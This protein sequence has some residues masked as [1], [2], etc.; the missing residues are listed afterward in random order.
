MLR[1]KTA[2]T[3]HVGKYYL[4]ES[5]AITTVAG[6]EIKSFM[7]SSGNRNKEIQYSYKIFKKKL[8]LRQ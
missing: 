1:E 8:R 6:I 3:V 7:K 4:T 2:P 5:S